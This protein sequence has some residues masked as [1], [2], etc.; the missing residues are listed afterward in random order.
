MRKTVIFTFLRQ[1]SISF[2]SIF[3]AYWMPFLERLRSE[4]YNT[5]RDTGRA[6]KDTRNENLNKSIR[7][8]GGDCPQGN[9]IC[10]YGASIRNSYKYAKKPLV[11]EIGHVPVSRRPVFTKS[12]TNPER[13]VNKQSNLVRIP[14]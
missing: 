3:D 13:I 10:N 1:F 7:H 2:S 8:G 9:W 12:L 14:H 11:N 5:T 4:V 6:N